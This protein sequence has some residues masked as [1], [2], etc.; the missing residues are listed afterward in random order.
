MDH[1][2]GVSVASSGNGSPLSKCLV[3]NLSLDVLW[4]LLLNLLCEALAGDSL[5]KLLLKVFGFENLVE[6]FYGEFV[7]VIFRLDFL[8]S[9]LSER[10]SPERE[11]LTWEGEILGYTGGF[12]PEQRLSRLGEKWHFGAV[13]TVPMVGRGR[14]TSQNV[15]NEL[16][17]QMVAALQQINENL[18]SLN[19][20][21][22]P[23]SSSQPLAPTEPAEGNPDSRAAKTKRVPWLK[24]GQSGPNKLTKDSIDPGIQESNCVLSVS[25]L[26]P[27]GQA[28]KT[29]QAPK[30]HQGPSDQ[31]L[32]GKS[33]FDIQSI[34]EEIEIEI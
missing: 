24:P 32:E 19:Q 7:I 33:K 30:E 15:L 8:D 27:T 4:D 25:G 14:G 6:I 26:S 9:R 16:L 23:S 34:W 21:T 22:T 12:S 1:L 13:E 18:H 31:C 2:C 28:P 20:N 10:F 29:P 5:V 3:V 17:A 11:R